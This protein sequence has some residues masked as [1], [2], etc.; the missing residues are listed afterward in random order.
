[1]RAKL[2]DGTR[3]ITA[4]K[5]VMV[6]VVNKL[7][8]FVQ[9]A[10][11]VYG[12]RYRPRPKR[13]SCRDSELLFPFQRLDRETMKLA[14]A[15]LRPRGQTPIGYS[16]AQLANDFRGRPGPKLVLLVSDGIETCDPRPGDRYYPVRM[17]AQ[18]KRKG[19]SM[20]SA[21]ISARKRRAAS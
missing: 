15:R 20:S 1:M 5:R 8:D 3:R 7:P 12:H 2:A 21:S 9:V 13:K 6:S 16:L 18:L 17:I 19:G 14:I 11:R 4:A 10:F